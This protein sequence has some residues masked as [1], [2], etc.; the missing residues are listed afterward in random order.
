ML[1]QMW[2]GDLTL[3]DKLRINTRV[4][5]HNGLEVPSMLQGKYK[6]IH[7]LNNVLLLHLIAFTCLLYQIQGDTCYACPTITSVILSKHQSSK[8]IY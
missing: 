7:V 5:G 2:E 6:I 8:R 4:I 1:K 3:E